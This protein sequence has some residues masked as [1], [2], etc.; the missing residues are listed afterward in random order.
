MLDD[1][2]RRITRLKD[3]IDRLRDY[4]NKFGGLYSRK[5][6]DVLDESEEKGISQEID[7]VAELFRK[8]SR[9]IKDELEEIKD[10][11]DAVRKR[12][13]EDSLEYQSRNMHWQRC[14]KNLTT[15]INRFRHEQLKYAR[16]EESKLKSQYMAINPGVTEEEVN[17]II[18]RRDSD[19]A[20]QKALA[21][22]SES[23]RRQLEDVKDKNARIRSLSKR[24]DEL[25][26]LIT[27]LQ[28]MV[29]QSGVV[30]DK[31]EVKMDKTKA[32]TETANKDLEAAYRYQYS[33]LR[34]ADQTKGACSAW[35]A[36]ARSPGQRTAFMQNTL[37]MQGKKRKATSQLSPYSNDEDLSV[38]TSTHQTAAPVPRVACARAE[39]PATSYGGKF[40]RM[41]SGV[42]LFPDIRRR[43]EDTRDKVSSLN[44]CFLRAVTTVLD[45]DASKD[46][47]F[48]FEQYSRHLQGIRVQKAAEDG[49]AGAR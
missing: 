29:S 38:Q 34:L 39:R 24:L 47:T 45:T 9:E 19:A 8:Q 18:S 43:E 17:R 2:L 20:M 21:G 33:H 4:T 6:R 35:K 26:E 12:Q 40:A 37:W 28:R 25:L 36:Q 49:S 22:G 48:L 10:E 7:A 32:S 41:F 44:K 15:E 27:E 42:D 30:V 23:S 14:T 1:F 11:N 5:L 46:L 31:I 16:D 3:S 13:K